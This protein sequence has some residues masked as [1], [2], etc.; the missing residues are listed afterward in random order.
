MRDW[1]VGQT[2]E[3]GGVVGKASL[4]YV[5]ALVGLRV[6]NRRTLSQWTAMDFAAAV[7]IGA[8]VGRTAIASGQS[9]LAGAVALVT[10]LAAHALVAWT[11][12]VRWVARTVDHPVR[13]LVHDG[14][15]LRDQVRRCALTDDDV[16]AKLRERGVE[17]LGELRY[18]LY[19]TKGDLTIV[20]E[21]G[22]GTPDGALVRSGLSRAVGSPRRGRVD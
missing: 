1:L 3:L 6:T 4:M 22:P 14:V 8:I 20:R 17:D 9:Y 7:A 12:R 19:E 15:L 21:R 18:V 16:L 11:R 13:V 5:T 2:G 10:L